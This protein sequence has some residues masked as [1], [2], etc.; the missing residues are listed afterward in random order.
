MSELSTKYGDQAYPLTSIRSGCYDHLGSIRCSDHNGAALKRELTDDPKY[1]LC[2][3][4]NRIIFG[5]YNQC[6]HTGCN[7]NAGGRSSLGA[8]SSSSNATSGGGGSK[9]AA[10]LLQT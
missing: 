9:I 3:R 7:A 5:A 4:C 1:K 8:A 6:H 2:T 10:Q